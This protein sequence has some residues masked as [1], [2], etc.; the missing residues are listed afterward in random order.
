MASD[1][2]VTSYVGI[3]VGVIVWSAEAV[4]NGVAG[5]EQTGDAGIISWMPC[6]TVGYD[7]HFYDTRW[8]LG[9]EL[10]FWHM[11]IGMANGD[12]I[13]GFTQTAT[14]TGKYFYKPYGICKLYGGA[15]LG[16][17]FAEIQDL[18][19][20]PAVQLNPIGMRLGSDKV[21]FTAELGCGYKGIL[22]LGVSVAL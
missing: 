10:G 14:V 5:E 21:G 9:G 11:G 22:Q 19:L 20:F 12:K 17:G 7:Y 6:M 16:I 13:L 18:T 1:A 15:N 4:A 8:N 2:T 3:L